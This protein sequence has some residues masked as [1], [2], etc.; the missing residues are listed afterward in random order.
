MPVAPKPPCGVEPELC[1]VARRNDSLG[2][3]GRRI[4]FCLVAAVSLT[5]GIGFVVAGAWPVLPYS[6]LE[7]TVLA[8]AFACLERRARDW[9]RLTVEGERVIVE[10]VQGGRLDRREWNRRWLRVET[11]A[12][13]DGRPA[14]MLLCSAG[15]AWEFGASLAAE[16]RTEVARHLRRLTGA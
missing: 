15:Q 8:V 2:T 12:G 14:R 5:L 10:R 13:D 16:Q 4:A 3:R 6:L 9:E 1:V 7:V 11:T